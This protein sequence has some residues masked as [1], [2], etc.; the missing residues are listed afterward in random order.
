LR[1]VVEGL[2]A[3]LI[4]G[5][6]SGLNGKFTNS[7]F[8]LNEKGEWLTP[9]YHKTILLAFG[10]YLPG[11][12]LIPGL[13]GLMPQ[14]EEFGR[15]PGPTVLDTGE[16]KFGA[17]ICYEALFDRFT[18]RLANQGAQVLVNLTNDSFFQA[19]GQQPYQHLYM[20]MARAIEVRRPMIRAT[21]TGISGAILAS[22]DV[23]ELSPTNESWW[24]FYEIP[25]RTDAPTTLFVTWGFWLAPVFLGL[26]LVMP[27]M[28]ALLKGRNGSRAAPDEAEQPA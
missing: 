27:P 13:R 10:E 9:P 26:A 11:A 8:V 3:K 7:F 24:H 28:G 25:Y 2:D 21:D 22:G 23:L 16:A 17:Q 6:Y 19:W 12:D 20:S 1:R 4:T 5:G 18:R 14:I 15:G